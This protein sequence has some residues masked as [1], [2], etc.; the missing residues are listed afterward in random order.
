MGDKD[1]GLGFLLGVIVAVLMLGT[2]MKLE[3][4]KLAVEQGRGKYLPNGTWV[5]DSTKV[6]AIATKALTE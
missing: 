4:R 2:S 6:D 3:Q 1:M 5:V